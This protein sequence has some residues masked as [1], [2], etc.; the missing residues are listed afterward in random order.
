MSNVLMFFFHTM[1]TIRKC[2]IKYF[3]V[4]ALQMTKRVMLHRL[5]RTKQEIFSS[6]MFNAAN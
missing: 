3:L 2:A 1:R 5:N 4:K 6:L